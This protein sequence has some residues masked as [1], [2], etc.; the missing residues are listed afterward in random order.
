[1]SGENT[2]PNNLDINFD[3][4]TY[5]SERDTNGDGQ[6]DLIHATDQDGVAHVIHVDADGNAL[7]E[8]VDTDGD[9][10]FETMRTAGEEGFENFAVDSDNDGAFDRVSV[11]DK[12]SQTTIQ[13][14]ELDENGRVT[15]T[16]V[17]LDRD[18]TTDMV[19]RDTDGDGQFDEIKFDSDSDGYVNTRMVDS[20]GDGKIDEIHTDVDNT[21]GVLETVTYS[22]DY[23]GG[24]GSVDDYT[25]LIPTSSEETDFS[26]DSD[27]G[28]ADDADVDF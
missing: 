16:R 24:L 28:T 18:G 8:E 23:A 26:F 6:T 17:D 3:D 2:S 15:E 4:F 1:M 11:V 27:A 19:F 13:Q 22:S 21:D 9:S 14:N 20:D 10:T 25:N 5:V 7:S 12:E